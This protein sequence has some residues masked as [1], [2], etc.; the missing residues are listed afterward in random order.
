MYGNIANPRTHTR[1]AEQKN[2]FGHQLP[3]KLFN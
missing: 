2:I 3:Q 1:R